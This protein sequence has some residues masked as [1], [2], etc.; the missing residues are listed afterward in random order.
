MLYLWYIYVIWQIARYFILDV[1]DIRNGPILFMK[2]YPISSNGLFNIQ[3]SYNYPVNFP[4]FSRLY[5]F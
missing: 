3:K 2:I 5:L 4:A 1:K